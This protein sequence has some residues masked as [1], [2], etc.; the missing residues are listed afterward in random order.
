[1]VIAQPP[2]VP[3]QPLGKPLSSG[4]ECRIGVSGLTLCFELNI[5]PDMRRNHG[6]E[7]MCFGRQSHMGVDHI[8]EILAQ[9]AIET[10][11][12]MRAKGVANV[13]LFP[14]DGE[15]H[16]RRISESK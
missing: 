4:I 1:M 3:P 12:D 6:A 11:G 8:A 16:S 13:E 5:A 10:I 15:L 7:E 2:L 14:F 9:R